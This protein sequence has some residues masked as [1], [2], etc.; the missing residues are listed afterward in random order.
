MKRHSTSPC[1]LLRHPLLRPVLLAGGFVLA[2]LPAVAGAGEIVIPLPDGTTAQTIR[3]RYDCGA[4]GMVEARYFNAPPVALASLSF[5]NEFVVAAN[6]LAASG[7]RYAGGKYVWWT[8][9]DTADLYDLT[10]GEG[11]PPVASC[12]SVP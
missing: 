6:V 2:L 10:S 4:F 5:K 3:A 9:G 7:A 8:K 1:G 11:A 12:S